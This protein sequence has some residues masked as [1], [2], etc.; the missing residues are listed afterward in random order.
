VNVSA[1][2]VLPT[3]AGSAYSADGAGAPVRTGDGTFTV[4][5]GTSH[6]EAV[7]S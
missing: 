2:I 3:V 6:F 4:G 7:P 5:S 1:T